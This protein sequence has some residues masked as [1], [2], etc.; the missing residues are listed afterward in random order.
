MIVSQLEKGPK[1]KGSDAAFVQIRDKSLQYRDSISEVSFACYVVLMFQ[2]EFKFSE[3]LK[4][5]FYESLGFAILPIILLMEGRIGAAN[6]GFI[7]TNISGFFF[8]ILL[9]SCYATL[10]ILF[11]IFYDQIS[12]HF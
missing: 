8:Q 7:P 12:K 1:R 5:V 9:Y 4:T 2:I 3:F 10:N 6:R 11:F